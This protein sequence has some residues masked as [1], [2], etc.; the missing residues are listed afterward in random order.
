MNPPPLHLLALVERKA[1]A[2]II[3]LTWDKKLPLLAAFT[4]V[5]NDTHWWLYELAP[6]RATEGNGK[7]QP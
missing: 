6:E 7:G 3:T 2:R 5:K 1:W 4:K